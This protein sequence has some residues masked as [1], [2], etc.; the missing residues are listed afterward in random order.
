MLQ[1]SEYE[2]L[3][4]T[5][6]TQRRASE[7]LAEKYLRLTRRYRAAQYILYGAI[8]LGC[9][10]G[11][12]AGAGR[13]DWFFIALA[14]CMTAASITLLPALAPRVPKLESLRWPVAAG[15]FC[16]SLEL[17]LLSVCAFAG[18]RWFPVA[19]TAT[20]FGLSFALLP[21]ALRAAPL[22][23]RLA[24]RKL[25][26]YLISELFLLEVLLLACR[27]SY[28]G[29]WYAGAALGSLFGLSLVI[30]PVALR[31]FAGRALAGRLLSIYLISELFLLEV[32]LLACRLSYGGGWY[33]GAALGSL[34]GLSL[35]IL[36]VAL[37]QC[38]PAPLN[39]HKALIYM[40][41]ETLLLAALLTLAED[42]PLAFALALTG[43]ALPWGAM[44]CARYLPLRR[45]LRAAAAL[46]CGALW[47]W[48]AP[49]AV[50]RAMTFR[51][52]PPDA[53]YR[54]LF[55][56]DLLDWSPA[57]IAPNVHFLLIFLLLIAAGLLA[58]IR[59]PR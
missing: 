12:L 38:L 24:R 41:A 54:L 25:S 26:I 1:I 4:G 14:A 31:Q 33:A 7:R 35:F 10:V 52:G 42:V 15:S 47:L 27:L 39:R 44:L 8:L 6:D 11:N 55:H 20:L 59:R 37:R 13:L 18:G 57:N 36:P 22:S 43:L 49:L 23:E 32:L 30:R 17:M 29:G 56:F 50:D 34:F 53:P 48:L 28:G 46:A 19:G 45:K 2:L 9:L 58:A 16:I 3:N 21:I 40:A 5:E 51:Y